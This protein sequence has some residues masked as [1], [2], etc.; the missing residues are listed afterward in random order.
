MKTFLAR[1]G[2]MQFASMLMLA[3]IGAY[4]LAAAGE[5]RGIEAF[6]G[7]WKDALATFGVSLAVYFALA[8]T[9]LRKAADIAVPIF[10]AA[11][12]ALL[13]AVLA[14]G[15]TIYGGKRWLWFFQPAETAKLATIAFVAWLLDDTSAEAK[16]KRT[17]TGF[18][19]ATAAI[20]APCVLILREPD[21]GSAGVLAA[22]CFAMLIAAGVWRK[23]LLTAMALAAIALACTLGAVHEAWRPGVGQEKREQ[24][25]K[26]VP[27]ANHQI[28]RVK[29]FLYPEMDTLGA[30]YNLKQAKMALGSCRRWAS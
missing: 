28:A 20:A 17:F 27:L 6:A 11:S 18:A 10:Y 22:S 7:K 14:F 3:A 16:W 9:N 15:S 23:W 2:W 29:T 8:A 1:F 24:I 26:Y 13:V 5:A 12:L 21:L 4:T 25:L 19:A 30:G